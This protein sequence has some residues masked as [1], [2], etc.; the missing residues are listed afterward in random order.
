MRKVIL[1][2]SALCLVVFSSCKENAAS[3]VKSENV[4]IAAERD[5]NAGNL[6]VVEFD[7][8]EHDFGNVES[9]TPVETV[10]KYTNVGNS[11]LV[12]SNVKSTCG[13]TIPSNYTKEVAPGETGEFS[14]KFKSKGNGSRVNRTITMT[15]NTEKGKETVKVTAFVEKDPNAPAKPVVKTSTTANNI[16]VTTKKQTSIQP[17]HEGHNHQ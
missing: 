15:T 12:V 3:K 10:F 6:P 2:L 13:C 14:V 11:M 1:G 5:A 4:A 8:I 16:P 9:N 7:K 17:G